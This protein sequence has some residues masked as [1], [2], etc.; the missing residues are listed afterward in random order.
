[1]RSHD[2]V[3]SRSSL[4]D[5]S[6]RAEISMAEDWL[7]EPPRTRVRVIKSPSR[8]IAFTEE[9]AARARSA[10]RKSSTA[11]KPASK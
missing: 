10:S 4:S 5:F 8:V 7:A 1:M 3:T 2:A 11:T 6:M 9:S